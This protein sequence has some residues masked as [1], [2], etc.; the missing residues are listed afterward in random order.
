[1]VLVLER[2]VGCDHVQDEGGRI[3]L[4]VGRRVLAERI[5]ERP[6]EVPDDGHACRPGAAQ[7]LSEGMLVGG[8]N[9]LGRVDERAVQVEEHN[10]DVVKHR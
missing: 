6:A 7:V 10:G 4:A 3:R 5:A 9:Q 2:P 8:K 1:M